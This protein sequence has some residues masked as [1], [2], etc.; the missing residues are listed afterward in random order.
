[1]TGERDSIVMEYYRSKLRHF[2]GLEREYYREHIEFRWNINTSGSYLFYTGHPFADLTPDET[3]QN[4]VRNWG[5]VTT[6]EASSPST[7]I[8]VPIKQS[9]SGGV[10]GQ[11]SILS[12]TF[13]SLKVQGEWF[14]D[15][16]E[17]EIDNDWIWNTFN[18]NH[19]KYYWAKN[20]GLIRRVLLEE[21]TTAEVESFNLIRYQVIQ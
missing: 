15:V 3:W 11:I 10:S 19:T 6:P 2:Q 14:Y 8:F 5:F 1:M 4:S 13:D 18:T 20:V 9:G 21:H 17:F 16:A 12:N 7:M